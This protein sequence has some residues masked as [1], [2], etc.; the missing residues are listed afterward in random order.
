[1]VAAGIDGIRRR[2]DPGPPTASNL[3]KEITFPRLPAN[4]A[5]G[6]DAF[7]SDDELVQALGSTFSTTYAEMLRFDWERFLRHVTDWEIS[8]YREML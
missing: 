4:P 6:L 8:E 2:L 1:M 3:F 5:E 7:L